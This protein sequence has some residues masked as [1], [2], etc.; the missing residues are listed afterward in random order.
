[1]LTGDRGGSR[2]EES[3]T[4]VSGMM[5]D[6]LG[7]DVEGNLQIAEYGGRIVKR[8]GVEEGVNGLLLLV[9]KTLCMEWPL[10]ERKTMIFPLNDASHGLTGP[11]LQVR[12][13]CCLGRAV[14][15]ATAGARGHF[16]LSSGP[17]PKTQR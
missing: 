9:L 1:M 15:A 12:C 3:N 14:I 11:L 10:M 8:S 7:E 2:F 16:P 4:T 6:L 17:F 13:L 5:V